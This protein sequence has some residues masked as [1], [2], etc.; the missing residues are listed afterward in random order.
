MR[1]AIVTESLSK[2]YA[3]GE[4]RAES[5]RQ[6]FAAI[7]RRALAAA[8]RGG[9]P[10]PKEVWALR[11]LDL[12]V[13]EGEVL[14]IVGANGAGK[15]TLLKI[16]S[17]ITDPTSGRARIRGRVA[18]LLEVGTGFHP[19]LTGRENVFLN[20]AIIGMRRAEIVARFDE[21]AAFAGIDRFL[22]TPVKRYSSGM[23]M[24][25]AFSVA[26]HLV[27]E[28]L[29][30][31]EV[32]AVGDAAF[33]QKCLGRME[34]M[35]RLGRTVIFV[36]HNMGAVRRLCGRVVWLDQG[37]ITAS[38]PPGE[39]IARYLAAPDSG[40]G[41]CWS[42]EAGRA[43]RFRYHAV[44]IDQDGSENGDALD[45]SRPIR[46]AF[47][48]SV[49]EGLPPGRLAFRLEDASGGVVLSSSSVDADGLRHR[50]WRIGRSREV[51]TLP[52]GWLSPGV[53]ALTISEENDDGSDAIRERILSFRIGA[54][55]SPSERDG[56]QGVLTP[57]LP[58]SFE[59]PGEPS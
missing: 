18:S 9:A 52:G 49:E 23:Y 20:G 53:Y 37:S 6:L 46:V 51:C 43:G 28:I 40:R 35:Q 22:D 50:P 27:S 24:R 14:G 32:L 26:A 10:E 48:Y 16:L 4:R 15:S 19:E 45:F 57:I 7:P 29:L 2:R 36:S 1:P 39:V 38:G 12:D 47:D 34:S 31:D 11:D 8:R 13:A 55:H 30:V 56:R 5:L 58:W 59:R 42:P 25:L 17:R 54:D 41:R 44:R 21:I 3:L 33:Q